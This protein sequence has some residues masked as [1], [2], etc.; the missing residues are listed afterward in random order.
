MPLESYVERR[1]LKPA[2]ERLGGVCWKLM[3]VSM[4]G[5]PDRLILLPGARVYFVE[6]KGSEKEPRA[7]QLI[8]HKLLK[9]LG[10]EVWVIRNKQEVEQFIKY[11]ED[12]E[13]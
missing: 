5:I 9:R 6:T 10:F 1:N 11:L 4:R 8:V 12:T 3:P 2:I 7:S 13:F